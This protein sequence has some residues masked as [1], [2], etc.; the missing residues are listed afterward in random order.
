MGE[1]SESIMQGLREVKSHHEGGLRLKTAA[2]GKSKK[3]AKEAVLGPSCAS[4]S[5]KRDGT[6]GAEYET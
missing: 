1:A 3:P 4:E 5:T 2:I 6:G